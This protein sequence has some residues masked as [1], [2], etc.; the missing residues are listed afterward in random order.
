MTAGLLAKLTGLTTGAITAALDR[1]EKTGLARRVP[2]AHDRRKVLVELTD[3][4]RRAAPRSTA[5]SS[6]AA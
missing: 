2:D 5:R 3:A 6:R 1:L 4:G